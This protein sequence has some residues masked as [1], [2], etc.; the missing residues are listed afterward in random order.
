MRY[1]SL[2]LLLF[3]SL[4][5][6]KEPEW[7]FN[8]YDVYNKKIY[9]VGVGN[10]KTEKEAENSAYSA[11]A[12]IFGMKISVDT[13]ANEKYIET[14]SGVEE[15]RILDNNT[16]IEAEHNLINVKIDE[17]YYDEKRDI[18]YAIAVLNKKETS[19]L[20]EKKIKE[21]LNI[22]KSYI[23]KSDIEKDLLNKYSAM[24][25]AY[26]FSEKNNNFLSQLSIIDNSKNIT[27]DDEFKMD[28]IKIKL[29]DIKRKITF[30]IES[31]DITPNIE[32]AIE[33]S[34]SELGFKISSN[35]SYIIRDKF[36]FDGNDTG[37][38]M[39]ILNYTL[40][41]ELLDYNG[42][43]IASFKFRGKDG[44]ASEKDAKRVVMNKIVREINANLSNQISDFLDEKLK[45]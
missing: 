25:I 24:Y 11:L 21:N 10:G 45:N 16:R 2:L 43:R 26:I 39:Y 30:S 31:V 27:I 5:F 4:L 40:I 1:I 19:V 34:I 36:T 28:N 33:H 29:E 3:S 8:P 14:S 7:I 12:N 17:K 18:Y 9:E 32:S 41:L 23:N 20:L 38:G 35:P 13:R 15:T 44:G 22:I 42:D 6:S 37:Y